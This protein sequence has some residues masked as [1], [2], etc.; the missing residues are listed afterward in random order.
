MVL[1]VPREPCSWMRMAFGTESATK[2]SNLEWNFSKYMSIEVTW[3]ATVD[4]KA[5]SYMYMYIHYRPYR[6][7][8]W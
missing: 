3:T 8:C 2:R 6:I 5:A 4:F 7:S 1:L